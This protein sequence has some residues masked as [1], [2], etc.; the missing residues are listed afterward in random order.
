MAIPKKVNVDGNLDFF[1]LGE[2]WGIPSELCRN[3]IGLGVQKKCSFCAGKSRLLGKIARALADFP[4]TRSS[5]TS[6]KPTSADC[7]SLL[8]FFLNIDRIMKKAPAPSTTKK[9]Q[10]AQGAFL[11][12]APP[13]PTKFYVWAHR[14]CPGVPF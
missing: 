7:L 1:F 13:P 10:T 6:K 11:K 3:P 2:K 5:A 4:K 12:K 14:H 9:S 8:F